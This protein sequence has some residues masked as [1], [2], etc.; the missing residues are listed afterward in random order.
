M[1]QDKLREVIKGIIK[2]ALDENS[3]APSKPK[4]TPGPA[5]A[6][7][8]PSTDK[9][10]PR[11]PLGNP[12]VKPNPKASMNEAEMLAKI[13]K[14]FKDK[15]NIHENTNS[16]WQKGYKDGYNEGFKDASNGKSNK[17]IKEGEF[18]GYG[19]NYSGNI[20]NNIIKKT[21]DA[22]NKI[23]KSGGY[24]AVPKKEYSPIKNDDMP[25][26]KYLASKNKN[27]G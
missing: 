12:N 24:N 27:N 25:L 4:E 8:K 1:K 13:I 10:K 14:R 19:S 5:I 17:F 2:K 20:K 23:T 15:K 16:D 18:K 11:R 7:G 9:P 3:P 21:S 26:D 6:P 22:V